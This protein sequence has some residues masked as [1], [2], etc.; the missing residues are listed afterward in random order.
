M[1]HWIVETETRK[2]RPSVSRATATIVV[3]RI[4]MIDPRTMTVAM[5]ESSGVMA[6]GVGV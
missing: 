2:S 5:R 1:T 6:E 3:S 4:A